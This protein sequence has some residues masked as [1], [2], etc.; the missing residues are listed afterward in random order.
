MEEEFQEQLNNL[1]D[2]W[3]VDHM[4]LLKFVNN[5]TFDTSYE[6]YPLIKLLRNKNDT[7]DFINSQLP[8][9]YVAKFFDILKNLPLEGINSNHLSFHRLEGLINF[10][11]YEK[12]ALMCEDQLPEIF[13]QHYSNIEDP[14]HEIFW[15]VKLIDIYSKYY[16]FNP[17]LKIKQHMFDNQ[18]LVF[19]DRATLIESIKLFIKTQKV[20]VTDYLSYNFPKS[21]DEIIESYEISAK[22]LDQ[23]KISAD[24]NGFDEFDDNK[25]LDELWNIA[26]KK[27][28]MKEACCLIANYF[29]WM[30]LDEQILW[31]NR[32]KDRNINS[33][34]SQ[35]RSAIFIE[36][37]NPDYLSLID[38]NSSLTFLKMASIK[39]YDELI[40]LAVNK[41]PGHLFILKPTITAEEIR[42]L[43]EPQI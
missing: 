12:L 10:R 42:N 13:I 22:L 3:T 29:D 30:P 27:D 5:N 1:N 8:W 37:A 17:M 21:V 39:H 24:N 11:F 14:L 32:I 38:K 20:D 19:H 4:K 35:T 28:I 23:I 7:I 41:F 36:Y 25:I 6:L 43:I 34:I 40:K 33:F 18:T 15:N 16:Q 2:G 9:S 31:W 26:E